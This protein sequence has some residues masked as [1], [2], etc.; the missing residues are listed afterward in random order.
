MSIDELR[1]AISDSWHSFDSLDYFGQKRVI[2]SLFGG[3][4][5]LT[6]MTIL[7]WKV[8][9]PLIL[10]VVGTTIYLRRS[11]SDDSL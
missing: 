3:I 7:A 9:V 8:M 1:D 10:F 6:V 2:G 4:L 11:R 5:A